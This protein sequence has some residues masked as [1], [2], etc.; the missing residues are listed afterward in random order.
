MAIRAMDTLIT[1]S[2]PTGV[3]LSSNDHD[4][5]GTGG[6]AAEEG[7]FLVASAGN[8]N[9]VPVKIRTPTDSFVRNTK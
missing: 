4:Q 7:K 2:F 1:Q 6:S 5:S 9:M 3:D 8:D